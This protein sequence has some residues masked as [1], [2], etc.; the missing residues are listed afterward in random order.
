MNLTQKQRVFVVLV[1]FVL[2]AL[3]AAYYKYGRPRLTEYKRA[4]DERKQAEAKL[5]VA[6]KRY[7]NSPNPG[8]VVSKI[9]ATIGPWEEELVR[10]KR[11]YNTTERR[12]PEG[13]KFKEFYFRDEFKAVQK[14]MVAKARAKQMW[15]FPQNLGFPVTTP[16]GSL[17]EPMLN[18]LY[19]AK[20]VLEV[21]LDSGAVEISQFTVGEPIMRQGFI[22]ILPYQI[23]VLIKLEDLVKLLHKIA[24]TT[25][26]LSVW[27]I[28]IN[29]GQTMQGSGL[30]QVR[31]V[32]FTT[33][34][35]DKD[36]VAATVA[37]GA[38][39]GAATSASSRLSMRRQAYLKSKRERT[40]Q[41]GSGVQE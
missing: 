10:A 7:F 8:N 15:N 37:T 25:Q 34:L 18:Q 16:P 28:G 4:A 1:V 6:R 29:G 19:N 14:E 41:A 26:Y 39:G 5:A 9:K 31:M 24:T 35:L 40:N 12:V 32:L 11:V 20:F 21:L 13:I 38:A 33:R 2:V 36:A 17:V 23:T 22:Q 30:L 3:G 27:S